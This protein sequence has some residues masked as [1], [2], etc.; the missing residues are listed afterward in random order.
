MASANFN[1]IM[2]LFMRESGRITRSMA[3]VNLLRVMA[4]VFTKGTGNMI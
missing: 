3:M 2:E 4:N 1:I